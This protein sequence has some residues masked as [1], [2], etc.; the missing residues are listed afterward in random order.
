MHQFCCFVP[1]SVRE[2]EAVVSC[3]ANTIT[4]LAVSF[5]GQNMSPI[6]PLLHRLVK[7]R[8]LHI[9]I[10]PDMTITWPMDGHPFLELQLLVISGSERRVTSVL[11]WLKDSS[12][13]KLHTLRLEVITHPINNLGIDLEILASFMERNGAKLI[14]FGL[15]GHVISESSAEVVFPHTPRL[16]YLELHSS[17]RSGLEVLKY[18][19]ASVTD[20]TFPMFGQL[21]ILHDFVEGIMELAEKSVIG[22]TLTT[23]ILIMDSRASGHGSLS[24]KK[25]LAAMT[26]DVDGRVTRLRSWVKRLAACQIQ[27]LDEEGQDLETVITAVYTA[28]SS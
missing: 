19:P 22:S 20:V 12:M 10:E 7:L 26:I 27:V 16:K 3:R 4:T 28:N 1:L 23:C 2:L 24:F 11:G 15:V 6:I 14:R 21:G 18:L 13:P 5:R 25:I 17:R 9:N 8:D